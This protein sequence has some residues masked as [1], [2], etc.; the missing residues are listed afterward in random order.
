MAESKN[1]NVEKDG[2]V[3]SGKNKNVERAK[4]LPKTVEELNALKKAKAPEPS[5]SDRL[6][7]ME[8]QLNLIEDGILVLINS[9]Q[10]ANLSITPVG[11]HNPDFMLKPYFDLSEAVAEL[12]VGEGEAIS[13]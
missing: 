3:N 7:R 5:K 1:T 6:D 13:Q 11:T 8:N 9:V 2:T 4:V 12:T 10:W